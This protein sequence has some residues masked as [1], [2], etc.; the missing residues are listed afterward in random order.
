MVV[1][2]ER[3]ERYR[4][5]PKC[6][7]CCRCK[8]NGQHKNQRFNATSLSSDKIKK[9]SSSS[10]PSDCDSSTVFC[11]LSYRS[12]LSISSVIQ[13]RCLIC[14]KVCRNIAFI[15]AFFSL[16]ILSSGIC[17]NGSSIFVFLWLLA[18]VPRAYPESQ[19]ENQDKKNRLIFTYGEQNL[20]S[21]SEIHISKKND[22]T[23]FVADRRWIRRCSHLIISMLN[24]SKFT[25]AIPSERGS[26]Q[27]KATFFYL[28][29]RAIRWNRLKRVF[30]FIISYYLQVG[31]TLYIHYNHEGA[32]GGGWATNKNRSRDS[33]LLDY[34]ACFLLS[35]PLAERG[36]ELSEKNISEIAKIPI[37]NL[38]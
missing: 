1:S 10:V 4:R 21:L 8:R 13:W 14:K 20:K 35:C 2:S 28:F 11:R 37:D 34:V 9:T 30:C 3:L 18:M 19:I 31:S 26:F 33:T 32:V 22:S 12:I 7:P 23:F 16:H 6:W 5:D 25:C 24:C 27:F 17:P 38:I 36:R 15:T 29:K